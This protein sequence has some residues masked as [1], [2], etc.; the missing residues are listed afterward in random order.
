[1]SSLLCVHSAVERVRWMIFTGQGSLSGTYNA[2]C[3]FEEL[4]QA[5]DGVMVV[6]YGWCVMCPKCFIEYWRDICHLA[7]NMIFCRA[8]VYVCVVCAS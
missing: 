8:R 3:L 1:M 5:V 6:C 7:I 2:V 4:I